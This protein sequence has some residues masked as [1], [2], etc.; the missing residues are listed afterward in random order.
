MYLNPIDFFPL[1]EYIYSMKIGI[2]AEY[3]PFHKG[4]EYHI[5]ELRG[6]YPDAVICV[7]MS[8]NYVQRG[9][10]AIYDKYERTKAALACGADL[11]FEMPQIFATASSRDFARAGLSLLAAVGCDA[12]SFGMETVDPGMLNEITDILLKEP[13]P[14]KS[15]LKANLDN[16]MSFAAARASALAACFDSSRADHVTDFISLPNNILAT[17]YILAAKYLK[18]S[19]EI[20][21]LERK[22]PGYNATTPANGM[23]SA[24]SLR[25]QIFS[26]P[27]GVKTAMTYVPPIA[28]NIYENAT[29]LCYDDFSL[30]LYDRLLLC[31][32]PAFYDVKTDIISRI[33]NN[34]SA[35][36]SPTQFAELIKAKNMTLTSVSRSLLKILLRFTEDDLKEA[37]DYLP[38][39]RLL[40]TTDAGKAVLN[41]VAD[42]LER[43]NLSII[44]QLPQNPTGLLKKE[45]ENDALYEA[46]R[47][48]K[49]KTDIINEY[50]RMFLSFD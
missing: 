3:N 49:S 1:Y 36:K 50:E 7:C 30:V 25:K 13:E 11:V 24:S 22:G 26:G 35:Y 34:L 47:A 39:V 5:N 29:P 10:P 33:K 16:G 37:E 31:D 23:S 17:E 27:T 41:E 4:H 45:I 28:K 40:G 46:V 14:F 15:T 9:E 12:I 8:G 20:L 6:K 18:I 19:M 2:I 44:T 43:F 32:Y 42:S 21:L 38:Y 48:M